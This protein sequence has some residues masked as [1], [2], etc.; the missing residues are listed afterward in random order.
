MNGNRNGIRSRDSDGTVAVLQ[1]ELPPETTGMLNLQIV[2][3][4]KLCEE[5]HFRL[6]SF[7]RVSNIIGYCHYKGWLRR[8]CACNTV[9]E[10]DTLSVEM[11]P[12]G[13]FIWESVSCWNA[14]NYIFD[15][16][17]TSSC[18]TEAPE[19]SKFN[20]A[21]PIWIS[22]EAIHSKLHKVNIGLL[23]LCRD[24][25]QFSLSFSRR[26]V[27]ICRFDGGLG[28]GFDGFG[29][30]RNC[31]RLTFGL[32]GLVPQRF[33]LIPNSA[34]L[35]LHRVGLPFGL[36]GQFRQVADSGFDIGAIGDDTK[37]QNGDRQRADPDKERQ[38][39]IRSE[40]TKK[41]AGWSLVAISSL[42]GTIGAACL[43][44]AQCGRDFDLSLRQRV[45]Y[46]V[47]GGLICLLAAWLVYHFAAPMVG[48]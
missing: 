41:I 24:L 33:H 17:S 34:D 30:T 32:L 7:Q 21:V 11:N 42:M 23:G 12:V 4:F 1:Y 16:K 29:L 47:F 14:E 10:H 2:P 25:G 22:I 45:R 28:T 44:A 35:I 39:F 36:R 37:G 8:E 3:I 9:S 40:S 43:M 48:F 31:R 20:F 38:P 6:S 26:N 15:R 13:H 46:G 5:K 27:G 19:E 18:V